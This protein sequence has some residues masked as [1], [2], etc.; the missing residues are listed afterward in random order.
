MTA[1]IDRFALIVTKCGSDRSSVTIHYLGSES[2][3]KCYTLV[4]TLP[5]LE[6]KY[7]PVLANGYDDPPNVLND[8]PR[9]LSVQV[10]QPL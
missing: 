4:S 2:R 8:M 1:N 6:S 10:V 9:I 5:H 3:T 7:L